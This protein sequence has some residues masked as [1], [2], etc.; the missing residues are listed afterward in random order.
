M[1]RAKIVLKSTRICS[2]K[3]FSFEYLRS[4][5]SDGSD[6]RSFEK[7]IRDY[8]DQF[9]SQLTLSNVDELSCR[10]EFLRTI[11]NSSS[12]REKVLSALLYVLHKAWTLG[13]LRRGCA[14][15]ARKCT[16]KRDAHAEM[17][18]CLLK[19]FKRFH[20]RCQQLCKF[21]T[22][23]ESVYLKEK[24]VQLPRPKLF[25]DTNMADVR[26]GRASCAKALLFL[27][28]QRCHCL[29]LR[30]TLRSP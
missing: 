13:T 19:L 14:V 10:V 4:G 24:R 30:R 5:E 21:V 18:F 23:K 12:E 26:G 2:P 3:P 9:Y 25:W 20:S 28:L 22:T 8:S 16:N 29:L 27:S 15:T 1:L 6:W 7:W 11:S 17:L